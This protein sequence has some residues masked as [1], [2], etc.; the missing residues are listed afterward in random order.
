MDESSAAI[1]NHLD[2]ALSIKNVT[3]TFSNNATVMDVLDLK[4]G[5]YLSTPNITL[6]NREDEAYTFCVVLY[7]F[8]RSPSRNR[9][10]GGF[11]MSYAQLPLPLFQRNNE[12]GKFQKEKLMLYLQFLPD[13][14]DQTADVSFAMRLRGQQTSSRRFDLQWQAGM[15]LVHPSRTQ[16]DQGQAHDFGT[17]LM[18]SDMVTSFWEGTEPIQLQLDVQIHSPPPSSSIRRKGWAPLRDLRRLDEEELLYHD[19]EQVRVGRVVVPVLTKLSQRPRMFELGVYPGVEYRIMR[20]HS[21]AAKSNVR[22]D[23]ASPDSSEDL[24]YSRPGVL[25]DL[26]PIYP[27]VRQLERHWPVTVSETE[28]PRLYTPGQYNIVSALG[29]VLTALAGLALAFFISQG[30]SLYYIPSRSM[31]P[32]LQV[33]DVLLVEKISPRISHTGYHAGDI[34]LFHPPKPLQDLV[35]RSGG[36]VDD[37]DLFVKRIAAEPGDRFRVDPQGRVQI[38]TA[39]GAPRQHLDLCAASP[40]VEP[41]G[42][43]LQYLPP[44]GLETLVPPNQWE[45][46]GDCGAVSIDARVWGELPTENIVGRP[47]LRLWPHLGAIPPLP[48]SI[49][50]DGK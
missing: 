34:V 42:L 31:E 5:E 24:F 11:G 25:F 12:M 15:R 46:L 21:P 37:R 7:P 27:L 38:A 36:R 43:L 48:E 4:C 28:I 32:T 23:L 44:H 41:L 9:R 50:G 39:A 26:K 35:T 19:T 45:V 8:G 3:L 17:S 20:I 6:R 49:G 1:R 33:G 29:S 47:L 30:I 16:L 40:E 22:I 10:L 18:R 14:L 13:S 2:S